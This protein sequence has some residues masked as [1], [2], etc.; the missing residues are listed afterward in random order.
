[1]NRRTFAVRLVVVLGAC[2][3]AAC[4]T[5]DGARTAPHPS[6]PVPP[7]ATAP[8]AAT[9]LPSPTVAPGPAATPPAGR[10]PARTFAVGTRKLSLSRGKDRPLPTTVWY[11]AVGTAGRAPARGLAPATGPFPVVLFS[12]GLTAQPSDYSAMLTRWARAG[13]VVAAPAYPYTSTGVPKFSPLDVINQ[14]ADASAVLTA[15]LALNS[16]AGDALRG[17]INTDRVAAAGHSAGG[18]T[19]VGLFTG[20]RD[21]RLDA[22][23]VLAGR[24][25]LAA[26]FR[27]TPAPML[28]VHGKRDRTVAY[29]DGLAAFKAVPWPRAMLSITEG[30]HLVNGGDYE[31]VAGTTVEFLRWSLYGDRA[32]KAR[33]PARAATD[34]GAKLIDEL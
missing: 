10:A 9:A 11:P 31:A 19:T 17:K 2:A 8:P 30:G 7:V 23:I 13:F 21:D 22:G 6:D 26:P 16:K 34:K 28:F 15:V 27:G 14:P 32:A 29:A 18:I 33:I 4:S 5:H 25:V 1:M 24:R 20:S 3:L 12:H